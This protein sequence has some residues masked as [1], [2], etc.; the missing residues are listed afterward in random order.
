MFSNVFERFVLKLARLM[1]KSA[2]LIEKFL[3]QFSLLT[4]IPELNINDRTPTIN[5]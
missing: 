2:H 4:Q 1:R 5:F 3:P